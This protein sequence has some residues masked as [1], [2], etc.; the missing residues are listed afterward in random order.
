MSFQLTSLAGGLTVVSN[1]LSHAQTAAV[2]V[3][4]ASGARH[5]TPEV[6]G[7]SHFLEHMAFKGTYTRSAQ[8][9]ALSLETVGGHMNAYTSRETTAYYMRVLSQ[10]VPLAC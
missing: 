1:T 6:M 10:D 7:V 9:I 4:V 3:W 8:D 5:E 2:G